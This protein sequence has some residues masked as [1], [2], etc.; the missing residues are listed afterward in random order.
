[1]L[2]ENGCLLFMFSFVLL[3]AVNERQV[4]IALDQVST[5][6]TTIVVAHRLSTIRRADWIVALKAGQIIE[7][8]T[9]AEL[10]ELGGYYAQAVEAQR[11]T[12]P[13]E[14][15][16]EDEDNDDKNINNPTFSM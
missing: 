7:Q 2:K 5:G 9:H 10:M 8:G 13:H 11:V 6:R 15:D 14:E 1:M 3:D 4:Q 16:E 12:D